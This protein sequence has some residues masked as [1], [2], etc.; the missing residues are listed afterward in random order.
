MAGVANLFVREGR[1][2]SFKHEAGR[3]RSTAF[4][5]HGAGRTS[6]SKF[7]NLSLIVG[8]F[9]LILIIIVIVILYQKYLLEIGLHL[10]KAHLQR[11]RGLQ[12]DEMPLQENG[13]LI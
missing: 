5:K 8:M 2:F 11:E 10:F 1:L 6:H 7:Q 3:T 4:I 12:R 9:I 13:N